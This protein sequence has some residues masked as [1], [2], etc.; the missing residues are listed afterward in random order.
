MMT[1]AIAALMPRSP[2]DRTHRFTQSAGGSSS[3]D[4][5]IRTLPFNSLSDGSQLALA[6]WSKTSMQSTQVR[7]SISRSGPTYIHGSLGSLSPNS[8]RACG[9]SQ[10]GPNSSGFF[11]S[12]IA[13]SRP[14]NSAALS[15]ARFTS[16][17]REACRRSIWGDPPQCSTIPSDQSQFKRLMLLQHP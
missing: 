14:V 12:V 9:D 4:S 5:R 13:S 2:R 11:R 8:V 3:L 17:I 10:S 1:P 6:N 7:P 15:D 16:S